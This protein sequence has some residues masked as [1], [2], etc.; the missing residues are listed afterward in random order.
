M[1]ALV[2]FGILT[3]F[4]GI[5]FS[6]ILDFTSFPL[7][8]IKGDGMVDNTVVFYMDPVLNYQIDTFSRFLQKFSYFPNDVT[9]NDHWVGP[10]LFHW[11]VPQSSQNPI[12]IKA[13]GEAK[14][15][16]SGSVE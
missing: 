7:I 13:K 9:K 8:G 1:F 16:L 4:T 3:G 12:Y 14:V 5:K 15:G 2:T 6:K 10:R 11:G